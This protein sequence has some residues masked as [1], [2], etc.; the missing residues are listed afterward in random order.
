MDTSDPHI[1]LP[2]FPVMIALFTGDYSQ[3]EEAIQQLID[4][5]DE[6][7]IDLLIGLMGDDN[8]RLAVMSALALVRFKGEAVPLLIQSLNHP[9]TVV[10]YRAIWVLWT[11]EDVRAVEPLITTLSY[12]PDDKVRRFAAFGLGQLKDSRALNPLIYA[13]ADTDERVRWDAAVALAKIGPDAVDSLV[14]AAQYTAPLVR[15]GAVN[16]LAWIRDRQAVE[17]VALALNDD[18]VHVRTRAAF[19]LGWIGDESAVEPLTRALHDFNE[20]VRMQAAA[21]LGW[22]RDP[23]AV[24]A[25]AQLLED[26]VEWVAYTAIEALTG[27]GTEAAVTALKGGL[28]HPN[29]RIRDVIQSSLMQLGV[30]D[31]PFRSPLQR[32]VVHGNL[33]VDPGTARRRCKLVIATSTC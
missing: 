26:H 1:S 14:A 27:L 31:P 2:V 19:A 15:A 8:E 24:P 22:L 17:A 21:A 29:Q 9:R 18:D 16:A 13:L 20:E 25:L 5:H 32:P 33:W 23:Q 30:Y 10:R 4:R 28:K 7:I 12:D 11:I 3:R 6:R